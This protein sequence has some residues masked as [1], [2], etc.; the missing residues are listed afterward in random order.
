[1]GS[2]MFEHNSDTDR[3]RMHCG[4]IDASNWREP[5]ILQPH[6]NRILPTNRICK[7]SEFEG[8]EWTEDVCPGWA[9]RQPLIAEIA[10]AYQA[11]DKGELST[12][13]PDPSNVLTEGVL[14]MQNAV[15]TYEQ[16]RTSE[17]SKKAENGN[18]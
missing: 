13:F 12:M 10:Q 5:M 6:P 11:Y 3:E 4:F 17:L 1:M 15:A 2:S 14:E 16:V 7:R 18:G 9:V 8:V